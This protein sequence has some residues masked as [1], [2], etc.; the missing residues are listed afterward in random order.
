MNFLRFAKNSFN[1]GV[2]KFLVGSLTTALAV[3][4]AGG[5]VRN[6]IGAAQDWEVETGMMAE[7]EGAPGGSGWE[8]PG[9]YAVEAGYW[10]EGGA[11]A[12]YWAEG[13]AEA[14]YWAEVGGSP[15]SG[16]SLE[17]GCRQYSIVTDL[18]S[19]KLKIC[20]KPQLIGGSWSAKLNFGIVLDILEEL[21]LDVLHYGL[22]AIMNFVNFE[23]LK[24]EL[25]NEIVNEMP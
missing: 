6:G 2:K 16:V 8:E 18:W 5:G 1:F 9:N 15:L 12:G 14:G 3:W 10:A 21:K 22:G 4:V 13:G 24:D 25:K 11:E 7:A 20:R 23:G 19:I 17:Y